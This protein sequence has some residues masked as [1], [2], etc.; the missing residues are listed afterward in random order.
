LYD[1]FVFGGQ[2]HL[3]VVPRP[4]VAPWHH[5]ANVQAHA[6]GYHRAPAPSGSGHGFTPY[7]SPFPPCAH[8]VR[9]SNRV[10]TTPST[11]TRLCSGIGWGPLGGGPKKKASIDSDLKALIDIQIAAAIKKQLPVHGKKSDGSTSST[12]GKSTAVHYRMTT[13]A[14]QRPRG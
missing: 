1:S 6:H 13:P 4:A 11:L 10:D 14:L 3:D 9:S 2:E 8:V 5:G 7:A 12:S